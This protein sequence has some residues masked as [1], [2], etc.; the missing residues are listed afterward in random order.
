MSAYERSEII[1]SG[2]AAKRL[3]TVLSDLKS[4][5]LK[6][7]VISRNN[8]LE[9]VILP[10]EEYEQLE[11]AANILEHMKIARIIAQR[12]KEETAVSLEEMLNE[13]GINL[14]EL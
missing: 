3:G 12:A 6:R 4:G 9:A 2:K 5:R 11:D 7:V 8:V 14:N 13:E 1:A 10:V